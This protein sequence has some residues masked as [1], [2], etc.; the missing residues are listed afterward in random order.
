MGYLSRFRIPAA[1]RIGLRTVAYRSSDQSLGI[2]ERGI[3]QEQRS[4]ST[5]PGSDRHSADPAALH[6]DVA[7]AIVEIDRGVVAFLEE[8]LHPLPLAVAPDEGFP[9]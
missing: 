8:E 7:F 9:E 5:Q 2:V 1:T 3:S 4:A 6:D